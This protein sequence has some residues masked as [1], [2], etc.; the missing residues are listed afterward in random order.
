[1][2]PLANLA[3]SLLDTWIDNLLI[4]WHIVF[5]LVLVLL[6]WPGMQMDFRWLKGKVDQG[7]CEY[8]TCVICCDSMIYM[9]SHVYVYEGLRPMRS[10]MD[11]GL[12]AWYNTYWLRVIY[13]LIYISLTVLEMLYEW[14]TLGYESLTCGL[15]VHSEPQNLKTDGK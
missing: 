2:Y 13:A 10:C 6:R 11:Y 14:N 5:Y 12:W 15:H 9:I 3:C 8:M 1:M 4:D 7:C